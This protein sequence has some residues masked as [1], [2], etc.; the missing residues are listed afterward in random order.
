MFHRRSL[1]E[2]VKLF[3]SL[4]VETKKPAANAPVVRKRNRKVAS[5]FQTQVSHCT[6]LFISFHIV[7]LI[8]L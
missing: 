1:A 6:L 2:K 8:Y 5:R 3:S 7:I 4:K